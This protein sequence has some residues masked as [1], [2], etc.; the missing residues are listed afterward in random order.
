LE[1]LPFSDPNVDE[2]R[3]VQCSLNEVKT[4][5]DLGLSMKFVNRERELAKFSTCI[6]T[7]FTKWETMRTSPEF[8]K[9][10]SIPCI[11]GQSGIG[12][13]RFIYQAICNLNFPQTTLGKQ[14]TETFKRQLYL[15][16]SF[17]GSVGYSLLDRYIRGFSNWNDFETFKIKWESMES[18]LMPMSILQALTLIC[19]TI[20]NGILFVH[21]DE[22]QVCKYFVVA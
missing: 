13:T 17:K 21:L 7:Y 10:I 11:G 15:R 20:K 22:S 8:K 18:D 14:L 3:F 12:K 4:V 9:E 1:F 16:C 6:E 5:S 19:R 2:K